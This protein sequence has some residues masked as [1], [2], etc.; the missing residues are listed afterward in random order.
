[1]AQRGAVFHAFGCKSSRDFDR[2]MLFPKNATTRPDL[3]AE[4]YQSREAAKPRLE[5]RRAGEERQVAPIPVFLPNYPVCPRS[6]A[7]HP[8][9]TPNW[10]EFT[11]RLEPPAR[12]TSSGL[13]FLGQRRIQPDRLCA[14]NAGAAFSVVVERGQRYSVPAAESPTCL[15]TLFALQYKT[16]RRC[17]APRTIRCN[18]FFAPEPSPSPCKTEGKNGLALYRQFDDSS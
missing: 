3:C 1:M 4:F 11:L 17:P 10:I 8:R 14:G 13:I 7:R 9:H 2:F 6:F 15:T 18:L 5:N 16:I 12:P